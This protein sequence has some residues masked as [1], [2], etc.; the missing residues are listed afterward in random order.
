MSSNDPLTKYRKARHN[1]Y[2]EQKA[3][4]QNYTHIQQTFDFEE[5]SQKAVGL[6]MAIACILVFIV[7]IIAVTAMVVIAEEFIFI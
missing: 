4:P 5:P 3:V 6:R 2:K 7:S 1:I